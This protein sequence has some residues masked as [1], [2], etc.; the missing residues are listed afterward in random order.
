MKLKRRAKGVT[1]LTGR[2]IQFVDALS[3]V[4]MYDEILERKS[5]SFQAKPNGLIIDCGANIGLSV[6]FF[7]ENYPDHEIIAFEPDPEV[8][9]TLQKNILTQEESVI[10]RIR[11]IQAAVWKSEGNIAFSSEG[12]DSGSLVAGN[13]NS[14]EIQ[15]NCKRLRDLLNQEVDFLKID[16]EGAEYEVILDCKDKLVNVNNLFFEFHSY[17]GKPQ[18]LDMLL[19]VV[20]EAGFRYYIEGGS[21]GAD[22]PFIEVNSYLGM[23]FQVNVFCF[24]ES[25]SS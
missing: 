13:S 7:A 12:S 15:I 3:F 1:N 24:R 8:F 23:D 6:I 14:R 2:P 16:I 25:E 19:R 20:S 21:V 5:Y 18:K 9:N 22:R 11:L 10:R 17:E 4:S